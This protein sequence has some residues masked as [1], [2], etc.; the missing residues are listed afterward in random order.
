MD[1]ALAVMAYDAARGEIVLHS[2]W[3]GEFSGIAFSDTWTFGDRWQQHQPATVPPT[4]ARAAMAYDAARAQCVL[5][6]GDTLTSLLGDTWVWDGVDWSPRSPANSPP[7]RYG[8]G[9]AD[10]R[11]RGRV[12][13]FGGFDGTNELADTWE[14]DGRDWRRSMSASAPQARWQ[15]RLVYDAARGVTMLFGGYSSGG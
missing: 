8:H 13:L 2:G 7:S 11:A 4:R 9:M 14:W 1:K 3:R 5:F 12:V 6:G 15:P 10:D